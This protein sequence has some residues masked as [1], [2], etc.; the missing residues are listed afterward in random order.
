[1]SPA[2]RNARQASA[3]ARI[4]AAN[5]ELSAMVGINL[6]STWSFRCL[7]HLCLGFGITAQT[8]ISSWF[9]LVLALL[10]AQTLGRLLEWSRRT[11]RIEELEAMADKAEAAKKAKGGAK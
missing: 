1:M 9:G 3:I 7:F 2:E 6:L 10:S 11:R 5:Q 4:N 8:G